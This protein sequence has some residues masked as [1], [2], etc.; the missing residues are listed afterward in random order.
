MKT[1]LIAVTGLLLLTVAQAQLM[2]PFCEYKETLYEEGETFY[3]ECNTCTCGS[4]GEVSCTEM[5]HC[6]PCAYAGPDGSTMFAY[7]G[8][9]NDGC[10]TCMCSVNGDV[11]FCTLIYCPHKCWI[12]NNDGNVGWIDEGVTIEKDP[13]EE[14]GKP[15]V[16]TCKNSGEFLGHIDLECQDSD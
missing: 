4:D 5:E 10:N 6:E 16:C 9:F 7:P 8:S 2:I 14:G 11:I 12:Q 13:E 1:T 3:D 15:Q